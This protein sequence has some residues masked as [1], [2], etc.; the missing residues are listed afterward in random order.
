M[1]HGFAVSKKPHK[2][3]EPASPYP[4]KKPAKKAAGSTDP[5][6]PVRYVD[7]DTARKLTQEILDKR[8]DLFRKLAQ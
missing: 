5:S 2:V 3:D 1:A 4:A 8:Q 7:R 6:Q